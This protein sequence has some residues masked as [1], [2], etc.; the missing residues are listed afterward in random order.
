MGVFGAFFGRRGV[1]GFSGALFGVSSGVV[2]FNVAMFLRAVREVFRPAR[3]DVGVSATKIALQAQNG[4]KTLLSG[5]LGEFFAETPLE[6]PCRASF[7]RTSSRR[8]PRA[9]FVVL[10]S[11]QSVPSRSPVI[12]RRRDLEG[13]RLSLRTLAAP[14][15]NRRWK[16]RASAQ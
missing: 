14:P 5:V 2:G 4:R 6:G 10:R 7:S 8:I 12:R 3:S 1:V 11:R 13:S 15:E 9:S 16:A